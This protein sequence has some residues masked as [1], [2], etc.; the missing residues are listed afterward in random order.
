MNPKITESIFFRHNPDPMWVFDVD[1]RMFLDV[2]D[3]ALDRYGFNREE[4]LARSIDEIRDRDDKVE[5]QDLVAQPSESDATGHR[6]HRTKSGETIHVSVSSY[7]IVFTSRA[8]RLVCAR[9]ITEIVMLQAQNA[10]L[11]E[12]ERA[13]RQ[14]AEAS[15]RYF[16]SLFETIPGKF[17]VLAPETLEIVAV[18]DEHL[19]ATMRKRSEVKGKHVLDAFPAAPDD[20]EAD[21]VEKLSESLARVTK[22]GVADVMAIQRYPIARPAEAGGGFEE[23][24]W[25]IV[26]TPINDDQGNVVY[27]VNRAEDVTGLVA[28]GKDISASDAHARMV[29]HREILELDIMLRSQELKAA[30]QRAELLSGQLTT[31]LESMSDAFFTLDRDWRFTYLNA[32]AEAL[33][34]RSREGLLGKRIWDEFDAQ[35]APRFVSEYARAMAEQTTVRFVDLYVPLQKWFEVNA[36]PAEESLAVYFRDVT[37]TRQR[38]EQLRQAQKMEVLGKLTGGIA[39]DFNNLL[40]VIMGNADVLTELL[41]HEPELQQ[42]ARMTTEAADRGAELVSRLLSFARRQTLVPQLIDLRQLIDGMRP[43]LRRALA[44]NITIEEEHEPGLWPVKADAAQLES[45]ILNVALNSHDA[46]PGGGK[47]RITTNNIAVTDTPGTSHLHLPAGDYVAIA[48]QDDGEGIATELMERIIDPFFTTKEVGKGSGLGLSMVSGFVEQSSGFMDIE[49]HPAYGTVV[50]LCFPADRAAAHEPATDEP[51]DEVL[52]GTE[53]V[54]LVEDND[55]VRQY[56]EALLV[57]LG[58]RVSAAASG[59]EALGLIT[60]GADFDL[61]LTDIIMPGMNGHDLAQAVLQRRPDI[62][63][64]YMSGFTD[65]TLDR[66]GLVSDEVAFLAKPFKRWEL[67]SALRKLL[68]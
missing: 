66:E 47:F 29:D 63:V 9:D 65:G 21:G 42:L 45:A 62:E 1:T 44:E 28:A 5:A 30:Q 18:S 48:M 35:G 59:R 60:A 43:L 27:I 32:Q 7:P 46:M 50:T 24:Y 13:S 61:L 57:S 39:H 36:Y 49:S 20:R 10:E 16:Q 58:Y 19:S 55:M 64:L 31:A 40:T 37:E 68:A 6:R 67:A 56:V 33:L 11:L 8:A 22:T 51:T 52:G 26:N 2:N 25:S 34:G 54:L 3:A 41:S 23:R 53:R 38:D 15:A 12:R 17:V 14:E 4:F